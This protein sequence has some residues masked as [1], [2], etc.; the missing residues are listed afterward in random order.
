MAP[1][2][3]PQCVSTRG[4]ESSEH[5][6]SGWVGGWE[7]GGVCLDGLTTHPALFP[8]N[9]VGGLPDRRWTRTFL[10]PAEKLTSPA[11]IHT[12]GENRDLKR[13]P[14]EEGGQPL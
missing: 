14:W 13:V 5:S 8:L 3:Q 1:A 10:T 9:Q 11:H 2:D 4:T 12:S 6:I 7:R